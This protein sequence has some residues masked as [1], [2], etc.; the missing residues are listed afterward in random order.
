MLVARETRSR[1]TRGSSWLGRIGVIALPLAA[2][3]CGGDS[4][5]AAP[6]PV[7]ATTTSTQGVSGPCY[8]LGPGDPEA[9]CG[10]GGSPKLLGEVEK[11]ID[12]LV[13]Y[14][15]QLFDKTD[16]SAPNTEFYKVVDREGYLDG[17]AVML[18]ILGVCSQ[19]DP[20]D[21]AYERIL[22]KSSNESS[23]AYDILTSD[24]Y[25]RR[26]QGSFVD[27]CRPASFP[28][29]RAPETPPPGSGCHAPYPPPVTRIL[30]NV[31]GRSPEF[32]TLDSTPLVGPDTAYC[33]AIGYTDGR[34]WCPVRMPGDPERVACEVWRIG[35][36]KD[37]GRPGPTWTK[38]DGSY[39]T[40]LQGNGCQNSPDNQ[41]Q[42][43]VY[44][45]GPYVAA[46]ANGVS[47]TVVSGR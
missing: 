37:T 47:C 9:A 41:F 31:Q 27:H 33:A 20:E 44:A 29:Q 8:R 22:V 5:P 42:L 30:C 12:L 23:E 32:D 39:C 35:T 6:R 28:L 18:R 13:Q 45:G 4:N 11:A 7:R 1:S 16:V 25:I 19:R 15:P 26:G 40:G 17:V 3:S 46:A 2:L 24:G 34:S 38:G 36:A 14:R 10:Q 21:L 43:Q